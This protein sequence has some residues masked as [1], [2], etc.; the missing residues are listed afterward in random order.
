MTRRIV[1][2]VVLAVV[3][4]GVPLACCVLGGHADLLDGVKRFPPRTEDWGF[5][6]ELLWNHR[7]PFNWWA[8]SGLVSFT[9]LCLFPFARR[10]WRFAKS[11][12]GEF[13]LPLNTPSRGR[14][15]WWGWL[16][17][18]VLVAGWTLS[19]N[20]RFGWFPRPSARVQ[21]QLSYAPVWAGFILLVNALCVKRS[22]HSPM[23]DHPWAYAAT[24]PASSLFWWFFEYL[25]RYVWNWYYLGI[26]ELG[27]AEYV[28]YATICFASVLP[29]V[30][31]VAALLHTFPVFDDRVFSGMARVDLRSPACRVFLGALAATGLCGIVFFPDYTYPL[32]WISP[33]AV[34]LLVQFMMK[35]RSVLDPVAD[36]NWSV[37]IRFAV[38]TLVCGFCWETWNYYALAK[39]VYAVPWAH[40]FQI[41]EMPLVGFAGYLPFGVECA[42]VTAWIMPQ[43]VCGDGFRIVNKS[44]QG[45]DDEQTGG[46]RAVLRGDGL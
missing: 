36:G 14:F 10:V 2:Y 17:L 13:G 32:L 16:G 34:F 31:A 8:F 24:F 5:R 44:K 35:E 15:P 40:R 21:V 26:S 11:R 9:L 18:A 25:N 39:W 22:G 12:G 23:T 29:G 3:L 20:Y 27:A 37:F 19:W 30:C 6:P 4:L 43:L 7:R 42:A 38:A 46:C 45:G 41:W 1:H 33:V 28:V